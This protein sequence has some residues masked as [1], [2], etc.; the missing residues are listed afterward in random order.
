[1]TIDLTI[2]LVAW[3][4]SRLMTSHPDVKERERD[5][6]RETLLKVFNFNAFL[7]A[8]LDYYFYFFLLYIGNAWGLNS[9]VR[10]V[11]FALKTFSCRVATPACIEDFRIHTTLA[12]FQTFV[13]C[14]H[15]CTH[16]AYCVYTKSD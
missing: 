14:V 4:L 5:G 9:C 8:E 7:H 10:R 11:Y 12:Q 2:L 6:A 16:K 1:M 15:M 3:Q 13:L